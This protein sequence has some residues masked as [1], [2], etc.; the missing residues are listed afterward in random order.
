MSEQSVCEEKIFQSLFL[1]QAEGLRNYL[2]YKT[3]NMQQAEDLTQEA[4]GKLW[5][6]CAKVV[7][8][9]ARGFLFKVAGNLFLN[10]AEHKK[11]VLKFQKTLRTRESQQTPQYL[12]EEKE[13]QERLER[14]INAL[15]EGQRTVFLMNRIDKKKYR[16]IAE[17]LGISVKAVEKR[18]H[19]ALS[20]LRKLSEKI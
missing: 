9:K 7:F 4:F 15:P 8:E 5:Q 2:Y 13:F 17:E 20:K 12:M 11:V 3:G 14:A 16:E 1:T 10:E 6:N 19:S 18:M